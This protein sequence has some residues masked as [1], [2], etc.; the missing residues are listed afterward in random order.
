MNFFWMFQEAVWEGF[1]QTASLVKVKPNLVK[2]EKT[3]IHLLVHFTL[4]SQNGFTIV[5]W[6]AQNKWSRSWDKFSQTVPKV[7]LEKLIVCLKKVCIFW[8]PFY[9][10]LIGFPKVWIFWM[11]YHKFSFVKRVGPTGIRTQV[12][13]FKVWSDNHY[14]MEP[15][16]VFSP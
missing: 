4:S 6:F 13:R 1:S 7:N 14:T 10:K 15:F 2:P 3:G 12:A 16:Y 11:A 8:A 5:S 9:E